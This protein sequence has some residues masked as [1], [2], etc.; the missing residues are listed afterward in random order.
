[1]YHGYG[2]APYGPYP[3]G[4]PVP[5]VGHDGQSYGSQQYQYPTQYYQQPT[6]TNAKHG[7]NGAS[8]QPELPS[9]ASQQAR[10]LVDATKATPNV[11]ANGMTTA[12]NSSLPR[13]Q[14]HLNV[15]VANNGS[16]G[17]GPMQGGGPSASNYGHSG[18]RS[19][20]Q[21]Y[22]GPVYSNGHQIPTASSTSY[23]SNSSST[24]SQSQRPTTN[25]MVCSPNKSIFIILCCRVSF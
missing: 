18:V 14:T 7:V 2:Y 6:P 21:W 15:S 17:R 20:T 24:K 12:H 16:Y 1:M 25:L 5:S 4:S 10:V 9:I 3:S 23:R 22:D 19:P 11:S 13:K 8:S